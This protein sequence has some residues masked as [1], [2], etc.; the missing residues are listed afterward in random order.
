MHWGI[1][2]E[3]T[4]VCDF[5]KAHI[6]VLERGFMRF[7]VA[8]LPFCGKFLKKVLDKRLQT[9]YNRFGVC[10]YADLK[11]FRISEVFRR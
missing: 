4:P 9:L 6:T 10:F 8:S 11:D 7:F 5:R 3:K 2:V 1:F